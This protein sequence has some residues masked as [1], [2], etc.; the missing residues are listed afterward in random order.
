[1]TESHC[2]DNTM[3]L[4]RQGHLQMQRRS[5]LF[6]IGGFFIG[7]QLAKAQIPPDRWQSIQAELGRAAARVAHVGKGLPQ[8][9]SA[10]RLCQ[11]LTNR[12]EQNSPVSPALVQATLDATQRARQASVRTD[13]FLQSTAAFQELAE[14]LIE[15]TA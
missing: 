4:S 8:T 5:V 13:A 3:G 7:S 6:T 11:L 15:A 1:M 10:V 9:Q 14:H 12:C 2:N